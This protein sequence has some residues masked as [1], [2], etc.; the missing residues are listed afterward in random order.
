MM[1]I[2]AKQQKNI[3]LVLLVMLY[4]WGGW[5]VSSM[6]QVTLRKILDHYNFSSIT[7]N[8]GLPHNYIAQIYKDSQGF[9]WF[10]THNGLSRYDGYSF[11]NYNISSSTIRLRSNFISGVCEDRFNRL[12]I[13][14]EAGLDLLDLRTN[15]L[16]KIDFSLFKSED[17]SKESVNSII[18]DA[19]GDIWLT[20]Q[21]NLY[22]LKF[23]KG[24]QIVSC[25][26]L[27]SKYDSHTAPITALQF[28]DNQVW[29]GYNHNVY[30][31]V[32]E[33]GTQLI[34][35]KRFPA[36][37]FDEQTNIHCFCLYAGYVWIGTDR[38]LYRFNSATG[39][40]KGYFSKDDNP[41]TLTQND[42]TALA[43]TNNKELVIATTKG[44]NFY[45]P[46]A[47]SFVRMVSTRETMERVISCNLIHCMYSDGSILWI[48]TEIGGVDKMESRNLSIRLFTNERGQS[49]S[50]PD[51]P[52]D[53]IFEDSRK[54]LWVGNMDQGLS[55]RLAGTENFLHFRHA[56]N[57]GLGENTIY[58]IEEDNHNQ[59]WIATW[60]GGISKMGLN[61]LPKP[62]FVTYNS[63]NSNL[64]GDY[65]G[66]LCYDRMN[67]G[68]WIG[69][70]KG[71]CFIDLKKN[72]I[73]RI[74]L[75]TDGQM[76]N[77]LTDMMIDRK[78]R[79]WIG[80][81]HGLFV[82]DLYSFAKNRKNVHYYYMEYKLNNP[83]SRLIEKICCIFEASDGTIWL[84]S[85]GYGVYR[86]DSDRTSPYKFTNL[87]V[88]N[89]LCD[90]TIYGI[91]EDASHRLWLSTNNGLSCYSKKSGSFSNYY[92][93]DGLLTDQ[94]YWN[95]YCKTHDGTLYFGGLNGMM[96]LNDVH[97]SS[98]RHSD[99]VVFTQLSVLDNIIVQGDNDYLEESISWAKKI[100]LHERDKSFS[101]EFSTLDFENE[102]KLKYYYRLAGFDEKWIECDPKRH[103]ASYTNLKAGHYIFQV[104]VQNPLNIRDSRI[105]EIAID[106]SPYFYKTW[107][108][109][110]LIFMAIA[111]I[112][113]Y[114][115]QWRVAIYKQQ[116][117]ELTEKVKERTLELE[118][119]MQVLSKQNDLLTQ[120]KKQLIELSKRI[121]EV[122][123]D[124]ISFFTNIT[125]EFRTPITLIMG[126]IDR[127][128]KLSANPKV[129][130]QLNIV[131]RNS[132]SLLS[133]VN[134]LLD[135]RKVESGKV[136]I[137][138]RRNNLPAFI[139]DVILPFEAF[140]KDRQIRVRFLMHLSAVFYEYDEEWMR[141]VIVNLLSNS[142][143]F[144]PNGGTVT[145]YIC[146]YLDERKR[147]NVYISVSDTGVG[148]LQ[149]DLDRI[150][151]RFYQSRKHV[152]FPMS[153]QSGTGIG[154][155]LCKRIVNEHGGR[156]YARNNS[157]KGSSMRILM[158][159]E[160]S[161]NQ[162]EL[163]PSEHPVTEIEEVEAD[164]P[165][166]EIIL[167]KKDKT[168]L[169]VDDNM[170]MRVY[171]RSILQSNYK[172]L[173]AED[174][175]KALDLLHTERIDF[176]VTDLMM[177]VMDGL[178]LSKR[179]KEDLSISHIP[180]L[181]LTA[182]VSEAARLDSFRIGVDEY[183]P[184]PFNEELLLLRIQNIFNVRESGLRQFDKQM[185]PSTLNM[186]E[187]SR[188][189]KFLNGIMTVI[190]TNYSN[191]EFDVESFASAVGISKTLLN[192]KLQSLV[193]QSVAKFISNY[194][195]NK[196]QELV[197]VNK[198]SKNMN[199]S[200]IAYEVGF[201]DPKYFSRCYQKKF[202]VLPS[203]SLD[204]QT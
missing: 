190:E 158:P 85:N 92:Q 102:G 201:N 5:D 44:L 123:T 103:Y 122:T 53:C 52:V 193:G 42:I 109:Y 124:K 200:E 99:R 106:V 182:K 152:K 76:N 40:R 16:E 26:A 80:S 133:L 50:L 146:S 127:A 61:R 183:L 169:V 79:L 6:A 54:N 114:W 184:K 13:A 81:Q 46:S 70:T 83:S 91:L 34:L 129:K 49:T 77:L 110:T 187:E 128:L 86:L 199:V 150:F 51:N 19:H 117:E 39:E 167:A 95:A 148:I 153:G 120:Q 69:T 20:T 87:T 32:G 15:K 111:L 165:E 96:G 178:E 179:V 35:G 94:F 202:G 75:S 84:G 27:M 64:P 7:I 173:E 4:L 126:P 175:E 47:D 143:K 28:I 164:V 36:L 137:T 22:H 90:N 121:Q 73:I 43:I 72:V 56:E 88:S 18:K 116:R 139:S 176:I 185:N 162:K 104:K 134:Q 97:T 172:V 154:L 177:P 163:I 78:Q 191:S 204:E 180:I 105:S 132:K 100:H 141:K 161:P 12:W 112:I 160:I 170:D 125:H 3:R 41:Q 157:G 24:G 74:G 62:S 55:L 68:L 71:L 60:G 37:A 174:G 195:L 63:R 197:Q 115:Y 8:D 196:A 156:I 166:K 10:S 17:L 9:L 194:R 38:G 14:S 113:F 155:Y 67:D 23:D 59:L 45:N 188:D 149:E 65:V 181:I 29:V 21:T 57:L 192:Q 98:I 118:D 108:F 135:F 30:K 11:V 147:N 171:V 151:D 142:M 82:L 31:V 140:A 93:K 203:A 66:S 198:T 144:T 48:G 136:V 58:D 25:S 130:E 101:I 186:D 189:S 168:I 145:L 2:F 107:W 1:G 138:K 131:E 33:R 159:M 119:K 89:G